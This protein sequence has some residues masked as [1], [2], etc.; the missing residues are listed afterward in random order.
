MTWRRWLWGLVGLI[1]MV[2][3]ALGGWSYVTWRQTQA[4]A[5]EVPPEPPPAPIALLRA[6]IPDGPHADLLRRGRYLTTAGDCVSCHTRAGGQPFAG[7]L[8]LRTPFGVIYSANLTSDGRSGIGAWSDD[9][10][11]R[12]M[13]R[14]I[15]RNG[16]HL[17]PAFPYPH[18]TIV[19][20]ED[21]DAILSWL[22]T[23]P[24]VRYTPPANLLPFPMDIRASMTAWNAAFFDDRAFVPDPKQSA[25]WNRGAYLVNGLGHCGACHSPKNIAGASQRDRHLQGGEL[26]QWVAP[27]L[28]GDERTGLGRWSAEDI[29][30]YLRT[31]RNAHANA[32][33]PMAEVVS[34]STSLLTGEDLGAIATYLKSQ[35]AHADNMAAGVDAA[36]MQRG[37]AIYSD[38]CASC[39]LEGGQG[40]SRR[41]PPLT[42]DAVAQQRNPVGVLHIILAGSRT[43]PTPERP[44]AFTMPSFAWKLSD[45]EAADVATFIRNSWG[46][47]APPVDPARV[48]DLRKTLQLPP[49]LTGG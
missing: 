10:F 32:G 14:G 37:A 3:L 26:N 36:S 47:R 35:P 31:G 27:N 20:R 18:F 12:A 40:Q 19:R 46:N 23:V 21:T 22:K 16:Q 25:E 2:L 6:P 5:A 34:Y 41:F 15:G 24:A 43:G 38:A 45:Q 48:A 7:G 30:E 29:V 11:Y 33:G 8:G 42:G 44:T 1:V 17:Y 49:K 39:H 4:A 28:T 13:S 9:D